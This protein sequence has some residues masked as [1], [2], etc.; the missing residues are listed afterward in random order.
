MYDVAFVSNSTIG[1][2]GAQPRVYALA[3]SIA[4]AV[5]P[6]ADA[7]PSRLVATA[8]GKLA[9]GASASLIIPL[10][11]LRGGPGACALVAFQF[12]D[13]APQSLALR[14]ADEA[15]DEIALPT[16]RLP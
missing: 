2:A 7:A 5:C 9:V 15:H 11:P 12:P 1:E 3:G 4:L 16:T 14:S 8:D 10:R 6:V 13:P